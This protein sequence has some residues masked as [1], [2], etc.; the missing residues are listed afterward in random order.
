MRILSGHKGAAYILALVTLVTGLVLG[1]AIL[2]ITTGGLI[3]ETRR[4]QKSAA[5]TLAESGIDYGWWIL[6]YTTS[7][8]L[9][10][11]KTLTMQTGSV[12]IDMIDNGNT[13]PSTYRITSDAT[14]SN[15]YKARVIR[16]MQGKMPYDYALA[17]NTNCNLNKEV[18]SDNNADIRANCPVVVENSSTRLHGDVTST[19]TITV[20]QGS[21]FGAMNQNSPPIWFPDIDLAS[22]QARAQIVY[23]GDKTFSWVSFPSDGTI[24]YVGGKATIS[25]LVNRKG[26]IVA[27]NGFDITGSVW[28]SS[29]G[30]AAM[31]TPK[32][33]RIRGAAFTVYGLLYAHNSNADSNIINDGHTTIYGRLAAD[34]INMA[35]GAVIDLYQ[36]SNYNPDL[37]RL[38]NLPGY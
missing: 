21:V 5:L 14:T 33:I 12:T 10:Q 8:N 24:I 36:T 4:Q 9:P 37:Y 17:I 18:W 16:T 2:Q 19:S 30:I 32:D 7:D 1:A 35:G 20:K 11:T 23:T 26:I 29:G 38:L 15:G 28:P 13:L 25:G 6:R 34:N 22:Y 31:V 27:A 3:S